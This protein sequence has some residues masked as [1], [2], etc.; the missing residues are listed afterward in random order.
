[1][2]TKRSKQSPA[3]QT[4]TDKAQALWLAGLGAI[5]LVQKRGGAMLAGLI[6]EGN[7]FQTRAQKLAHE[8]TADATVHVKGALAPIRAGF[9][10]NVKKLGAAVQQGVAGTLARLGIP[11]KT[12]IDELTQRV[13]ALS[14]RLK[15]AK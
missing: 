3:K 11:S 2:T 8:V 15:T 9:K 12:D 10:R 6:A 13:A 14:K 5:S 1:M 7:D 4:P